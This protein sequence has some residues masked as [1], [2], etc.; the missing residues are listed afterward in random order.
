MDNELVLL[1]RE[2]TTAFTIHLC[3]FIKI[4]IL[5]MREETTAFAIHLCIFIKIRITS[6]S[7]LQN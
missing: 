4:Q 5:L 6:S 2:E 7:K 3:I 1:M